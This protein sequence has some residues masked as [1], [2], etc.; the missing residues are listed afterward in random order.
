MMDEELQTTIEDYLNGQLPEERIQ[1]FETKMQQDKDLAAE[2]ALFREMDDLLGDTDALDFS[3]T[4]DTVLQNNRSESKEKQAVVK[5]MTTKSKSNRK[6]LSIAAGIALI[7]LFGTLIFMNSTAISPDKLYATHMQFPNTLGGG[8]ALRSTDITVTTNIL[9][10]INQSWQVA[11]TAYQKEEYSAA[12]I[13]LKNIE[14]LDPN[15]TSESKGD[16]YFKKGLVQ[17]KLDKTVEAISSF[18]LVED[19]DYLTNAEWKKALALLKID[20]NKAKIALQKIVDTN[21]PEQEVA[22]TILEELK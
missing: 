17:L 3:Q 2:V 11:N 4:I 8:S 15:F 9:K 13:A 20:T 10:Q 6:W 22:K 21:H 5:Q 18:E 12:L 19:G 1:A 14:V 16:Y 7:A